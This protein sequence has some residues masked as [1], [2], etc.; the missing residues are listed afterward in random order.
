[1]T[2]PTPD[3]N[4]SAAAAATIYHNS[5]CSTSRKALEMLQ[6]HGLQPQVVEY[7]KTPLTRPQL[8]Q[9]IAASGLTVREAVRTKEALYEELQLAQADDA[10]LLDAMAAH[11]VL[12]NR[13]FVVTAKGARLARPVDALLDIL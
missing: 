12:L 1:M 5:R 4:A 7:L 11:P 13:P 6:A 8:A 9:L 3:T 10:A 2:T